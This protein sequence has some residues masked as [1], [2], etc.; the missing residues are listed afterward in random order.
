MMGASPPVVHDGIEINRW[1][2]MRSYRTCPYFVG[3][4]DPVHLVL[5]TVIDEDAVRVVGC[6]FVEQVLKKTNARFHSIKIF[7]YM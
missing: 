2:K 6:L 7:D 5:L 1:S 3:D 4:R